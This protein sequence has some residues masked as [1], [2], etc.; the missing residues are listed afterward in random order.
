VRQAW[1]TVSAAERAALHSTLKVL[2]A[3]L[4]V[5]ICANSTAGDVANDGATS[6]WNTATT[7]GPT[8]QTGSDP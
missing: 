1:V 3:R 6:L 2:T 5:N 8:S 7:I 4:H